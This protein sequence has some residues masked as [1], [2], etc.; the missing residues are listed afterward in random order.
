MRVNIDE[1]SNVMA[2]YS[3]FYTVVAFSF[4][5]MYFDLDDLPVV[6]WS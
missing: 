3:P 4:Y 2:R 5:R 6:L 1:R